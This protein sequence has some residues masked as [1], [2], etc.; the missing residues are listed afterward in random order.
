VGAFAV[1]RI[2]V[3]HDYERKGRLTPFSS[4]LELLICFCYFFFPYIYAPSCWAELW[5]CPTPIGPVPRTMGLTSVVVGAAI[6]FPAMVWL[7]LR[8]SV[9][10]EPRVLK[11][12]GF[13][14][15]TRNP[16]V[17]GGALMVIG[18]AALWPSWY[19]LGWV[20]LY[21]VIFHMMVLTEEEHLRTT[22]GEEYKRY[23][24]RVPRYVGFPRRL[25]S[26]IG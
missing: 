23:C 8:R 17:M 18:V 21:A 7:G 4:L 24:E 16:Q 11:E 1:F 25:V 13:Y 15:V 20:V 3:R 14:R 12:T 5:S 19:A 2:F 9:G 26:L 22:H 10:Q 6:A